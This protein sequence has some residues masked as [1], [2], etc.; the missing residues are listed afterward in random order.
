MHVEQADMRCANDGFGLQSSHGR[1]VTV[2]QRSL[3]NTHVNRL[4]I[5]AQI[6]NNYD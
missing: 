6:I 4:K 3:Q 2:G 5:A 1:A